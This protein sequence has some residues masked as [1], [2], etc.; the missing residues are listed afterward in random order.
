MNSAPSILRM[1]PG[2]LWGVATAA[3]QN[4]GGNHNNQWTV[5]EQ[6]PGR[7]HGGQRSGKATDWWN[8]E[9]AAGD[10]D[11]A[12]EIGL[13]S[14]RLSVEWSRIEPEPGVFDA[15]ALRHYAEM[16][17][18]LRQRGLEPMVTLH[19]FTD[20]LWLAE[21]GGWENPLVED[22][23]SRFT[24]R[25]VDALGDQVT[26]WCTINEPIVYA[27][28]GYLDGRFPPGVKSLHRAMGVL[29]RML[30]AHGRAYRTIHR[31]QNNACAG[32]AHHMRVHLPA[33]PAS[34]V[35]RRAAAMMN[36]FGNR[37]TLAA[38]TEGKLTPLIGLG[39][40][41]SPLIDTSD[42]IGLNYYTTILTT[43]D[44]TRPGNLFARTFFDPAAEFS[45]YI[46]SG[47][48]YGIVDPSGLY[49]AL[50]TLASYG[51]P[52]YITENGVPD[53]D[54]DMRG[55]FI[56]T[57]LAETWRA[58]QEGADVRGYYHWTLVDNFEWVE[59][60]D[61]KF[62]LFS[63]DRETGIRGPKP[64]AAIYAQIAQANGVPARLLE[65]LAPGYHAKL[66]AGSQRVDA[67]GADR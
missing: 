36:Q 8:L 16:L 64:S 56:A 46:A 43:V 4:E 53:G 39:Q 33:N 10:F 48:P 57:H 65:A 5:W 7:I 29:R 22:Y 31:L 12:A 24:A 40:T 58:L 3:H 27:V 61:L 35:D 6:Q 19:H 47:D 32:L 42:Y 67:A 21:I 63:H 17:R 54:D 2:F 9:T 14:L 38:I 11:R 44:P 26:L 59:A 66:E 23:F 50:K 1:P 34:A 51:K 55:R 49:L 15:S 28:V 25:V 20:P 60:W 62:G 30:L 52:I 13:N 18:L 41:K 45:D 37:S